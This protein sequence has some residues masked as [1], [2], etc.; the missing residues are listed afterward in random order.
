[1]TR[2]CNDATVRLPSL[3]GID[4]EATLFGGQAFRWRRVDGDAAAAEG[5]VHEA[6]PMH[7]GNTG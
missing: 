2:P 6:K 7:S 5:R 4:L 1:M 3:A